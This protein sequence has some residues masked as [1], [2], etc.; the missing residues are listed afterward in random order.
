MTYTH[1]GLATKHKLPSKIF[2]KYDLKKKKSQREFCCV[3]VQFPF[4]RERLSKT[5]LCFSYFQG[6]AMGKESQNKFQTI[7]PKVQTFSKPVSKL[8]FPSCSS[9]EPFLKAKISCT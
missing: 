6:T 7:F 5:S 3:Y 1:P 9:K 8:V 2:Q 4:A